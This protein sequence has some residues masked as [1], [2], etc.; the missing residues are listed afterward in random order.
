MSENKY[1]KKFQ[2]FL[3]ENPHLWERFEK[4]ANKAWDRGLRRYSSK[5][6]VEYIR[7]ET[8]LYENNSKWKICNDHTPWLARHYISRHPDR[9]GLF[10]LKA[11]RSK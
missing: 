1:P 3:E 7:H 2:T 6:I 8:A 11:I 4:E 9:T 10:K 5:A